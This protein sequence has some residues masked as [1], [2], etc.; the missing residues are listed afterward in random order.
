MHFRWRTN[1]TVVAQY[2]NDA[3]VPRQAVT[4]KPNE[5]CVVLENGK[6]VGSVSQQHLEVN[7]QIGLFSKLFGKTNPSSL[8]YVRIYW[9]H[10]ILVQ[11]RGIS[12]NG[13]KS[14]VWSR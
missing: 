13:M 11:V 1:P 2:M 4:L 6:I 14:T 5:V 3:D 7:P 12:D 10:S 9:P 8:I